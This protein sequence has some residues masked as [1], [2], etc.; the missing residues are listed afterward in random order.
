MLQSIRERA[1]GW[2]AWVVFGLISV[3]FA[4]WG[5]NQY[6]GTDPNP[7][8]AKVNGTEISLQQFQ[9]AY[10]Q[11]RDQLRAA[12]G[13]NFD[14]SALDPIALRDQTLEQM[15]ADEALMHAALADG[16]RISD[17]QVAATIRSE[18]TFARD[19]AFSQDTYQQWLRGQGFSPA[20]FEFRLRRNLL[21]Q[22]LANGIIQTALPT[23]KETNRLATLLSQRRSFATLSV[24]LSRFIDEPID[25][26]KIVDYYNQHR[27]ELVVP[28][29]VA[30]DYVLV[31]RDEIIPTIEVDES[32][33][34]RRYEL[35][36]ANFS[37]PEQRKVS[38]IMIQVPPGA[39]DKEVEAA[40]Q[41]IMAL[42]EAVISG[43]DFATVAT[44]S[45]EDPG[46]AGLGGDLGF[47]T[48]G[49]MDKA[50]EDAAFSLQ[51]GVVSEPV[52]SSFGFHLILV[53]DIKPGGTKS[54]EEVRDELRRA[55]QQ[56]EAERRF[57]EQVERLANISF[58]VPDSLE[59]VADTLGLEVRSAGPLSRDGI[60]DD[61]LFSR[62]E[63]LTALF[64]EDVLEQGNNSQPID[65]GD[66]RVV[67][68]RAR[69]RIPSVQQTLDQ[70][71]PVIEARLKRENAEAKVREVGKNLLER[72]RSGD[73]LETVAAETGGQ[74]QEQSDVRRDS[75]D[76]NTAVLETAFRMPRPAT[77]GAPVFDGVATSDGDFVLIALRKVDDPP[78]DADML[79]KLRQAVALERGRLEF[80]AFVDSI[81]SRAD[82]RIYEQTLANAL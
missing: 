59:P 75:G 23:E 57:F 64:S 53:T 49:A 38:H 20:S 29:R 44:E 41:R 31:S 4:L 46:S 61:P 43:A 28:E 56:D 15:I 30:A 17:Q 76:A 32:A 42:R 8:V 51:P 48:P 82:V 54:F 11:Q 77:T 34:R 25:E 13:S 69:E 35:E 6:L 24:P 7:V 39:D 73:A 14:E 16:M 63:V 19:G 55:Y 45:S 12:L 81:R 79:A 71:R 5:V 72:L 50:F 18:S 40:R 1:T 74:W 21:A 9:Q 70:A 37:T 62:P 67:V 66:G 2:I 10:T 33:L 3:P 80:Q 26:A 58:E 65:L 27:D 68:V 60:P 78:P 22:Q 36:K 52:R 47:I